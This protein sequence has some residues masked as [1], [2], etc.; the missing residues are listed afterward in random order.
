MQPSDIQAAIVANRGLLAEAAAVLRL[1][2]HAGET[3]SITLKNAARAV[4]RL[5]ET[6]DDQLEGLDIEIGREP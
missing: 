4:R 1:I 6:V 2:D 3:D 5:V